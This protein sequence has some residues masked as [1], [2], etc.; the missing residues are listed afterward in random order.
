MFTQCTKFSSK[1][2][3]SAANFLRNNYLLTSKN[4]W[5]KTRYYA[6]IDFGEINIG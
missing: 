6:L 1:P 4:L 5:T 3:L 2:Q